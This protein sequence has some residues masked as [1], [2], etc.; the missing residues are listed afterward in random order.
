[1]Y[2]Y[3]CIGVWVISYDDCYPD[4]VAIPRRIRNNINYIPIKLHIT[5]VSSVI[6]YIYIYTL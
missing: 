4:H 1:M 3:T 6:I 5:D 2:L